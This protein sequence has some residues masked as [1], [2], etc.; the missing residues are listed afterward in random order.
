MKTPYT[1]RIKE[2]APAYDPRHIEAYIRL[3]HSTM[4]GLSAAQFSREVR[5]AALCVNVAGREAAERCAQSFGL[6][7][8]NYWDEKRKDRREEFLEEDATNAERAY[9]T[10]RPS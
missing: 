9:P 1:D 10:R 2:L 4:D 7:K 5:L 3:E 6:E 8:S